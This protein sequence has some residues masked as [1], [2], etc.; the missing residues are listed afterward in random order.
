MKPMFAVQISDRDDTDLHMTVNALIQEGLA[1]DNFG[2]I[3]FGGELTNLDAFPEDRFV[4]P[5]CGISV[6]NRWLVGALPS[7]WK[8]FY[9]VQA[10]D[11]AVYGKYYGKH[12]L[13]W[14]AQIL[15]FSE[16]VDSRWFSD[17]FIKP[18]DDLKAFAGLMLPS[19]QT[20]GEALAKTNHMPIPKDQ[21]VLVGPPVNIGREFRLFIVN[22]QIADACQYRNRG[23]SSVKEI[24]MSLAFEIDA[25]FKII[26]ELAPAPAPVYVIDICETND[27]FKIVEIN[28]FNCSGMYKVDRGLVL[29]EVAHFVE[30]HL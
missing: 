23:H 3:Y 2:A 11:Q 19:M 4:I 10:F 7:N 5:L 17:M 18:T 9:S 27:G 12:M 14:E 30:H 13:N 29:S 24:E 25:Y 26:N 21:K 1:Y 22:N 16:V 6:L 20:L 28:C 8:M 15:D